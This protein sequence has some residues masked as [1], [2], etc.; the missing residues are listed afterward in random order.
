MLSSFIF[1]KSID[2]FIR[3]STFLCVV[4]RGVLRLLIMVLC[5]YNK[6]DKLELIE[7][8]IK[9]GAK[10]TRDIAII[11]KLKL[12]YVRS[13]IREYRIPFEHLKR[14]KN[15]Q[16]NFS[17]VEI[18]E[19]IISTMQFNETNN[20]AEISRITNISPYI[21]R[22]YCQ[23][24]GLQIENNSRE[25]YCLKKVPR[26]KNIDDLLEEGL[27]LKE[28]GRKLNYSRE[29][30]RQYVLATGQYNKQKIQKK[31]KRDEREIIDEF[32][33]SNGVV[34]E[35]ARNLGVSTYIVSKIWKQMELRYKRQRFSD[36]ELMNVLSCYYAFNADTSY[37]A[38][39][40]KRA[41]SSI[42]R[43]W[44]K[45]GLKT[46]GTS[47]FSLEKR[48]EIASYFYKDEFYQNSSKVASELGISR[49]SVYKI[50]RKEG[51]ELKSR[52]GN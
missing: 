1:D 22:K 26:I 12:S 37:T 14:R 39:I 23:A 30:I 13:A 46:K 21:I 36:E 5:I 29:T 15:N 24:E 49:D 19:I 38:K 42:L 44:Q 2:V 7:K 6:Q 27:T 41:K 33:K 4:K 45:F 40:M 51:F 35:A 50:W 17:P 32:N 18:S 43:Q 25:I 3:K 10:S 47:K 9:N 28:I 48:K 8:A 52:T 34:N 11:T 16:E 20:L 31:L